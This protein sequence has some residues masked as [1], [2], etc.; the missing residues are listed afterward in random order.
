MHLIDT[1][2]P[3][4]MLQR[5]SYILSNPLCNVKFDRLALNILWNSSLNIQNSK[6]IC[7]KSF[8]KGD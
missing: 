5:K 1:D 2:I 8:A 3:R 7:H 4:H 6:P